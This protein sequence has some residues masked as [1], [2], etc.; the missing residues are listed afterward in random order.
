MPGDTH[1]VGSPR[2]GIKQLSPGKAAFDQGSIL[3]EFTL[4]LGLSALVLLAM[5]NMLVLL[6][7]GYGQ[8]IDRSE[9]DYSARMAGELIAREVREACQLK[10]SA[11]GKRLILLNGQ[12]ETV[13]IY[14]EDGQLYRLGQVKT[15]VA[16]NVLAV[17]FQE[18][19][20]MV[21]VALS[22]A[23]GGQSGEHSFCC[24]RRVEGEE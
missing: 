20:A 7:R 14:V 18:E 22:L 21:E 3:V 13:R 4:A 12:G 2:D 23:C 1:R 15:P 10:V 24:C 9:L 16:E 11:D 5:L 6:Q 8:E 19:G 17:F